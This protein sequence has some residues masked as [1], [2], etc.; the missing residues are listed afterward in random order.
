MSG[1]EELDPATATMTVLAGTPLERLQQAA[2]E[3]GFMVALDL[4][5]RGSCA[6]GG[7]IATNAGGNRVIRYGMTRE[8]I[9]GLEVVLPDGTVLNSLNKLIKNNAGY[10]LKQLFIG[11]EGT[12]GIVTRAVVRLHPRPHSTQAALCGLA[13]FEGVVELLKA[14]RT[15]LGASLSAFEVM[16]GGYYRFV[17]KEI[18]TIRGPIGNEHALYVLIEQQGT[19]EATDAARFEAWMERTLETGIISDAAL[20]QSMA[21]VQRFWSLR[22]C[23][24]EFRQT[25]LGPDHASFDI[26][27]PTGMMGDYVDTCQRQL[28]AALPGIIALF[29]GHIGDGNLHIV[30]NAP[31]T[32]PLAKDEIERIVYGEVRERGGTISAEH[33]I[34][35]RKKPWLG[36]SRTDAEIALMRLLKGAI[37]PLGVLNR[38]KVL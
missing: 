24:A 3:A 8:M 35:T 10:D 32:N 15:G 7:N 1:I 22:D 23:A 30:A 19:D 26:G 37:D 17:T 13:G 33:G 36:Y 11:S 14:A 29:Y 25:P 6:I 34:G 4:G 21:D 5:A 28:E 38:G 12:L 20:S 16:W 9:L 31:G 18:P 27:L 2:G